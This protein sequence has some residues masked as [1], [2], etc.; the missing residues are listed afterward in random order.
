MTATYNGVPAGPTSVQTAVEP[1]T[2][3][4]TFYYVETCDADGDTHKITECGGD[5]CN[6]NDAAVYPGASCSTGCSNTGATYDATCVCTGGTDTCYKGGGTS[7]SSYT[8]SCTPSWVCADWT[9]AD[10][11]ESE[12]QTRTCQ[13]VNNCGVNTNKPAE[14]Q[15]CVYT[16]SPEFE[17]PVVVCGDGACEGDET[18]K[19][20]EEDCGACPIPPTGTICGNSICESSENCESCEADCGAC[21]EPEPPAG[22]GMTGLVPGGVAGL[23]GIIVLILAIIGIGYF[24]SAKRKN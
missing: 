14:T 18:C 12:I 7:Y 9:P 19:S 10:C 13:D 20:C 16:V 23:G 21:Q 24:Y 4:T 2:D 5:D 6:D 1:V 22:D 11:P 15:T 3:E 17:G 8:T